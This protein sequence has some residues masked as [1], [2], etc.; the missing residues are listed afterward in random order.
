[1]RRRTLAW[2]G[3]VPAVCLIMEGPWLAR[4][5]RIDRCLDWGGRWDD[6]RGACEERPERAAVGACVE[7]GGAWDD[8]AGRCVPAAVP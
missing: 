4:Q 6:Q 5:L 1:V 2:A 7:G 3:A 8:R